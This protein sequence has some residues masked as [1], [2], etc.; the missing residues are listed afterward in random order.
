MLSA[1]TSLALQGSLWWPGR[2]EEAVR[3]CQKIPGPKF[4]LS[5]RTLDHRLPVLA[6]VQA[7]R[8]IPAA[9]GELLLTIFVNGISAP[10][11]KHLNVAIQ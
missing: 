9:L 1:R 2:F 10:Q 5:V 3:E 8:I 4:Q 6:Y 7:P 11:Y